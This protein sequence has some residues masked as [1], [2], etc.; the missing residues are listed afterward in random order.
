MRIKS[1][2]LLSIIVDQG[3]KGVRHQGF[4]EAGA[5]DQRSYHLANVL[6]GNH[7][8]DPAIEILMGRFEA[9]FSKPLLVCITGAESIIKLNDSTQTLNTPFVIPANGH[10]SIEQT[11]LGARSYLAVSALFNTPTFLNSQTT[12]LSEQNGG[13][14]GN[15]QGLLA[16]EQIDVTPKKNIK[17]IDSFISNY[18]QNKESIG[19]FVSSLKI[20]PKQHQSLD[21][22][23]AYQS[24]L[25]T[26][27]DLARFCHQSYQVTSDSNRMGI[28]LSARSL[29]T[30]HIDFNL[31]S[32][33]I[34]LGA[35]QI[36]PNGQPTILMQERQTIGGYPK[37]GCLTPQSISKLAQ[38]LPENTIEFTQTDLYSARQEYLLQ[39]QAL[40]ALQSLLQGND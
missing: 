3:R 18:Q 9:T 40:K 10:L 34:T 33:G 30:A 17:E 32:E 23:D 24:S 35:I 2:G 13:L 21:F 27:L 19:S 25:F 6:V 5:M 11:G 29:D 4:T 38:C 37:I 16:G 20:T 22:I 28:R 15:G 14:N 39:H 36:M 12:C 7:P 26:H 8:S 31:F 1:N